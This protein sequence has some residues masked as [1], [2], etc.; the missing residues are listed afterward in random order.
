[1][2]HECLLSKNYAKDNLYLGPAH[3]HVPHVEDFR[4]D[5]F[6]K[7]EIKKRDWMRMTTDQF[8]KFN[9]Q[10]GTEGIKDDD[11]NLV[12]PILISPNAAS[13]TYQLG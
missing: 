10:L 2:Q 7:Y 6:D 4:E 5:C 3:N 8:R 1:M 12:D 9:L 13:P 11:C